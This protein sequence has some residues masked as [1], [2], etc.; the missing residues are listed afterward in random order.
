MATKLRFIKRMILF[1]TST[2][3]NTF[4]KMEVK[5]HQTHIKFGDLYEI[6]SITNIGDDRFSVEFSPN[7]GILGVSDIKKEDFEIITTG[8]SKTT[9]K[10]CCGGG[11]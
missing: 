11:K 6:N 2:S 1:S 8:P 10:P 7:S 9:T 5:K 4:G 3:I